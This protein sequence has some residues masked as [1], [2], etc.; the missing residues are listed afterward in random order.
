MLKLTDNPPILFPETSFAESVTDPWRVAHTKS[1]N[2]KALAWGLLHANIRYFLPLAEKTTRRKGRRYTTLLPLF[3]GYL[4]FSG[5][6]EARYRALASNRVSQIIEVID[7]KRLIRELT[8]IHQALA[9]GL[10]MDPYPHLQ[11]GDRCR[12]KGGPLQGLEG[13]LL[14]KKSCTRLLLEV[15]ILGQAAAVEIDADLL[16]IL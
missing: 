6:D 14:R 12:V 16:D 15:A 4:F 1:R 10:P 13:V 7:Q 5:D 3:A 9:S 8:Q 11:A 2:E